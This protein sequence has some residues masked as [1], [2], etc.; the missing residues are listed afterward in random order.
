MNARS[1]LYILKVNHIP[2]GRH[3]A[4]AKLVQPN[5]SPILTILFEFFFSSSFVVS[6]RV[7]FG[8]IFFFIFFLLL[9]F[10]RFSFSFVSS[11]REST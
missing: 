6:L 4:R 5:R 1:D 10:I 8:L 9:A 7:F 11:A 3:E 2:N